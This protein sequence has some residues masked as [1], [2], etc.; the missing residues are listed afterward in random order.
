[1]DCTRETQPATWQHAREC[2]ES[3]LNQGTRLASVEELIDVVP[4]CSTVTTALNNS[5]MHQLK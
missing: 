3:V 1:M 5:S 4:H 2:K